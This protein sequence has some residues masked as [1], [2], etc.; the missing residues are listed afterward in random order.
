MSNFPKSDRI[1]RAPNAGR[2]GVVGLFFLFGIFA[3]S[4]SA[5]TSLFRVG[6][7]LSYNLS[8]G[9]FKD[10]GYAELY[11]VSRGKMGG[12]DVVEIRSKVKTIGLVSA[13]FVLLDQSRTIF[14]AQDT[15]LPVFI[16]R[17]INDGPL[18]REIVSN[19]LK[20]P[21]TNFDLITLLYKVRE[22]SGTG[23]YTF[24]EG[25]Q[26]YTANFQS[27]SKA[28]HLKTDAGEFD[29]NIVTVQ[30]EFLAMRGIRDMKIYLSADDARLP[31]LLRFKAQ[32]TEFRARLSS[33]QV[34]TPD[35]GPDPT[36]TNPAATPTPVTVASPRPTPSPTPYIE[37]QP[38]LPELGFSLGEK[39]S[40]RIL[41]NE[42]PV[43]TVTFEAVER[44][45]F[46]NRDSLL[47]TAIVTGV[48][49][50]NAAFRPADGFRAQVDPDT[51]APRWIETKVSTNAALNQTATFDPRTGQIS[52]GGANA[53]DAPIGTH[54][55]LSL[56]YAMRSF[57]LQPSLNRTNPVNDTRVAVFWESRP[58]I[59]T[60]RPSPPAEITIGGGKVP[61]QLVTINTG[62]PQLDALALKIWLDEDRVP[63]KF[64][65][66]RYT[67]ELQQLSGNPQ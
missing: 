29:T 32:K 60:L 11:V 49:R 26:V 55:L 65:F 14:A 16:R 25:D 15:G 50:P 28:E 22:S 18:P 34:E 59:F 33:V 2:F 43:A 56:F 7:K 45:Q 12:R 46:Q 62:D 39:L 57:N 38:L 63:I 64:G 41:E 30:S 20:D 6:E 8:F 44:K 27:G 21:T 24:L 54:S 42:Q 47:L 40:Y 13:S 23:S 66:G 1:A 35:P 67:A 17:T 51:L 4:A 31:V 3:A 5:Q 48:D 10:G 61:A 9:N 53:V 58:Y 36:M 19:Y 37:N 52:F